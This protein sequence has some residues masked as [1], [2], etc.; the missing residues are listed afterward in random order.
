MTNGARGGALIQQLRQIIA[1]QY[2]WDM[3]DQPIPRAYG[4]A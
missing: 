2:G 3:L 1:R 4:P